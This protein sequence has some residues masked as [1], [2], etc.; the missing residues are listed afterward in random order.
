MPTVLSSGPYR[1]FFVSLDFGEPPHVHVQRE[2]MVAKFWL[3]PVVLE[4]GGGFPPH[5][6]GQIA[7][8]VQARRC[9]LL[10]RWHEFFGD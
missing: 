3:E 7:K 6:L 9:L 2:Q 8:L 10:E 4:H 5:E 1:F